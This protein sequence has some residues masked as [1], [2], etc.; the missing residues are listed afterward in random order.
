MAFA[1]RVLV[2]GVLSTFCLNATARAQQNI[3]WQSTANAYYAAYSQAHNNTINAY[4]QYASP[5]QL[6][7]LIYAEVA[8]WN[9]YVQAQNAANA[10][11]RVLTLYQQIANIDATVRNWGI[12]V[13]N[14]YNFRNAA[15]YAN[16]PNYRARYDNWVS[17]E[18]A[19]ANNYVG[20]LQ[21]ARGQLQA[22]INQGQT[23]TVVAQPIETPQAPAAAP[24][25]RSIPNWCGIERTP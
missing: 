20:T 8:A 11:A 9:A 22:Q 14:L 1:L 15:A 12:Y 23:T 2:A 19:R 17:G 5:D 4:Y 13:Q 25:D 21:G 18:T 16:D 6:N 7:A 3:D 10:Q 24:C